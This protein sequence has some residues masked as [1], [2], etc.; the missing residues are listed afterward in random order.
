MSQRAESLMFS[1]DAMCS[2]PS[3]FSSACVDCSEVLSPVFE[4]RMLVVVKSLEVHYHVL[5]D[6]IALRTESSAPTPAPLP[7]APL[8]PTPLLRL[9]GHLSPI[10]PAP[11]PGHTRASRNNQVPQVPPPP[12]RVCV[13]SYAS[14]TTLPRSGR[15][16]SI[17]GHNQSKRV[18]VGTT[19]QA[20]FPDP[21]AVRPMHMQPVCDPH[22]ASK[23]S[24]QAVAPP[25][26][27]ERRTNPSNLALMTAE[28]LHGPDEGEGRDAGA[29]ESAS[30]RVP[31]SRGVQRHVGPP[32]HAKRFTEPEHLH[33]SLPPDERYPRSDPQLAPQ[34]GVARRRRGGGLDNC[35]TSTSTLNHGVYHK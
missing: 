21:S 23:P 35:R 9:C 4:C 22:L 33:N 3:F 28:W 17:R 7:P 14:L 31:L 13:C 29:T 20:D 34:D 30:M 32:E 27:R 18:G 11:T 26:C 5:L 10:P 16:S 6:T 12:F 8:P 25:L 15:R 2:S 1:I 24:A 19:L